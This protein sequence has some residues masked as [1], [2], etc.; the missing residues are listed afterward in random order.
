MPLKV[1]FNSPV[2]LYF[3]IISSIS[4]LVNYLT[5]GVSNELLFVTYDSSLTNPLTFVRMF[6]HVLGHANL[7][8]YLSNMLLF[9]LIGPMLEEKYGSRRIMVVIAFTVFLFLAP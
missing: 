9:I 5:M 8:H 4:L 1:T 3:V 6:T 2:I 7:E